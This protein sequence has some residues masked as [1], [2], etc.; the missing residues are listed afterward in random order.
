[1]LVPGRARRGSCQPHPPR[2]RARV[3]ARDLRP[4]ARPAGDLRR[5]GGGSLLLAS[6]QR[7]AGV[8]GSRPGSDRAQAPACVPGPVRA[9]DPSA[10]SRHHGERPTLGALA[11]VSALALGPAGIGAYQ[12][13]LNFAA[14][15]PVNRELTL[16]YIFGDLTITRAVQ[17]LIALWSL[18][19]A[20]RM[21]RRGLEWLFVCAIVGGL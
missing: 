1:H 11:A 3:A 12:E 8:G 2:R 13:R 6:A 20:Y 21:R 15:V 7:P 17:V 10:R 4:A 19:L 9:S 14:S 16:A 5:P 18:F